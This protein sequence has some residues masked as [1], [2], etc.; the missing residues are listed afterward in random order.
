MHI[1]GDRGFA[2][3]SHKSAHNS[4]TEWIQKVP[5]IRR[6]IVFPWLTRWNHLLLSV[7]LQYRDLGLGLDPYME[8]HN[9]SKERKN[10]PNVVLIKH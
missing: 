2:R 10:E 7:W 8:V 3:T 4:R 1:G 5:Q 9:I 6:D